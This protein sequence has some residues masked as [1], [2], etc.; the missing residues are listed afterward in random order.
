VGD[1]ASDMKSAIAYGSKNIYGVL[2]GA[3]S[4]EILVDAGATSV[5]NSVVDILTLI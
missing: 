2:S 1:T 3:H 5:V 4:K